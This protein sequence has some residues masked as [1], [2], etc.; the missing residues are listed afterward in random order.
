MNNISDEIFYLIQDKEIKIRDRYLRFSANIE[1]VMAKCVLLLNETKTKR[2]GVEEKINLKNFMFKEKLKKFKSLLLE[3]YPDLLQSYS[4]LFGHIDTFREMRN[5]MAHCYFQWD[6][7]DLD[8]VTIWDLDETSGTQK[9][10]STKYTLEQIS[11]SLTKSM[12]DIID[13]LNNLSSEIIQWVKPEIPYM[14]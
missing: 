11:N 12:K 14:F 3:I 9:M 10:E 1:G 8:S 5:K 2:S 6:E 7:N 13:D 4:I